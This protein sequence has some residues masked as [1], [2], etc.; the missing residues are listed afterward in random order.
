[1][2]PMSGLSSP[3]GMVEAVKIQGE[4]PQQAGYEECLCGSLTSP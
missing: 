3:S 1:M 2:A 4:D